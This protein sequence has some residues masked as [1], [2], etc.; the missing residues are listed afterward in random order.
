MHIS[1]HFT[2]A[3][4]RCARIRRCRY[5]RR[6]CCTTNGRRSGSFSMRYCA[7][8]HLTR[9]AGIG[10][11]TLRIAW[12]MLI[13]PMLGLSP[14]KTNQTPHNTRQMVLT[15]K[16]YIRDVT[17]IESEWLPELA[18]HFYEYNKL[19]RVDS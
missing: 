9:H 19:V 17:A 11:C 13:T 7:C 1:N 15:S 5:T 12:V 2:R 3:I 14:P 16:V 8:S 6:Q 18:P 10:R 4:E